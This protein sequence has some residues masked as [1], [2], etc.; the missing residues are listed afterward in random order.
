MCQDPNTE[1]PSSCPSEKQQQWL[2]AASARLVMNF[3][4]NDRHSHTLKECRAVVGTGLWG[5]VGGPRHQECDRDLGPL[6]AVS[7]SGQDQQATCG[8]SSSPSRRLLQKRSRNSCCSTERT[9][10]EHR[11]CHS[12]MPSTKSEM[13]M[14]T[15]PEKLN[16]NE[17]GIPFQPFHLF[18]LWDIPVVSQHLQNKWDSKIFGQTYLK[19][20]KLLQPTHLKG[21]IPGVT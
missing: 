16:P 10:M 2:R 8:D 19:T 14:L 5:Q 11:L 20:I 1:R 12:I 17:T 7:S 15:G 3:S 18:N 6:W 13:K 9:E 21:D 4:Q